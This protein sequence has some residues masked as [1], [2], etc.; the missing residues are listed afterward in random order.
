MQG[1]VVDVLP[2]VAPNNENQEISNVSSL[3]QI[4]NENQSQTKNSK[5]IEKSSN[6]LYILA[7]VNLDFAFNIKN[8]KTLSGTMKRKS[9]LTKNPTKKARLSK[10]NKQC[11][12]AEKNYQLKLSFLLERLNVSSDVREK[13]VNEQILLDTVHLNG[14]NYGN[15]SDVFVNENVDFIRIFLDTCNSDCFKHL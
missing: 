14:L 6:S 4:F 11:A 8:F 15:L 2:S 12:F 13:I 7:I 10:S 9:E 3:K 1:L 5:V